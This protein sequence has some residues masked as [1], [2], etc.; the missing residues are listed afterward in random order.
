MLFRCV[1][2]HFGSRTEAV[3]GGREG[4][5]FG[6]PPGLRPAT[7]RARS[8]PWPCSPRRPTNRSRMCKEPVWRKRDGSGTRRK[9]STYITS[10]ISL[11]RMVMRGIHLGNSLMNAGCV[12]APSRT[13]KRGGV[14]YQTQPTTRSHRGACAKLS[15]TWSNCH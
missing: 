8:S 9:E 10:M 3:D 13:Q 14:N 12:G 6:S 11:P 7:F 5:H 15:L 2:R 1:S 4:G